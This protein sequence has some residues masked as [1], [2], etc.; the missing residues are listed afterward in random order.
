MRRFL[1]TFQVSSLVLAALSGVGPNS[2]LAIGGDDVRVSRFVDGTDIFPGH[3]TCRL[4]SSETGDLF[5]TVAVGLSDSRVHVYRSADGGSD[6]TQWGDIDA[7]FLP[8]GL[9]ATIAPGTP[10]RFV[11]A[12]TEPG[13]LVVHSAELSD[14]TASF[15]STIVGAPAGTSSSVS[16]AA[17][18]GGAVAAD[19]YLAYISDNDEIMFALSNDGGLTFA[20][21]FVLESLNPDFYYALDVAADAANHVRLVWTENDQD[22]ETITVYYREAANDGA[23]I[24]DW[25]AK[26]VLEVVNSFQSGEAPI[27]IAASPTDSGLLVAAE[28]TFGGDIRLYHSPDAGFTWNQFDILEDAGIPDVTWGSAGPA[29]ACEINIPTQAYCIAKPSTLDPASPWVNEAVLDVDGQPAIHGTAITFD[30]T[31]ANE[32]AILGSSAEFDFLLGEL[33]FDAEWR[34]APGYGLSETGTPV[35]VGATITSAPAIADLE[36]D[37]DEDVVFTLSDSTVAAFDLAAGVLTNFG[38]VGPTSPASAPLVGNFFGD[39]AREIF[40]GLDNGEV[41]GLSAAGASLPGWPV[42]LGTSAPVFLS[43]GTLTGYTRLETV[44]ASGNQI[45]VLRPDGTTVP[46]FP[47][48]GNAG[49]GNVVG[50]A[51]VGDLDNDG[52]T[53]IVASFAGQ[54]IALDNTGQLV[55]TIYS[56]PAPVSAGVTLGDVDGDGDL[57]VALPLS[58]GVVGLRHHTGVAFGGG[59]PY[60]TGTISPIGPISLCASGTISAPYFHFMNLAGQAFVV[61]LLGSPRPSFPEPTPAGATL[62]EAIVNRLGSGTGP[63]EMLVG[64]PLGDAELWD[65]GNSVDVDGWRRDVWEPVDVACGA[66]DLDV[67]GLVEA[68]IPAGTRLWVLDMGVAPAPIART[69]QQAGGDSRRSACW[70]CDTPTSTG[71]TETTPHGEGPSLTLGPNPAQAFEHVTFRFSVPGRGVAHAALYDAA[72]RRVRTMASGT[73][74]A[75]SGAIEWDGLDDQGRAVSSGVYWA[76]VKLETEDRAGATTFVRSVTRLR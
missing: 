7:I 36:S 2:A 72:G 47:F 59:F 42:S 45:F 65:T 54:V 51:A 25:S 52:D 67:D 22:T 6:W 46:G 75:G 70:M 63:I 66:A 62:R 17:F 10:D 35:D 13:D 15:S 38:A 49:W 58:T 14:V 12:R 20:A 53:E 3:S 11:V 18:D 5:A 23:A 34:D 74:F 28:T 41:A 9:D 71:I 26:D 27:S 33:W 69:W 4:A 37:G 19:V 43:A 48:V 30:A 21:P 64:T 57:E 31:R 55:W 40:V 16:L 32:F 1:V 76:Q 29:L 8:R 68:V 39:A 50:R 24:G 61:D 73:P 60:S 56:Q 44:A